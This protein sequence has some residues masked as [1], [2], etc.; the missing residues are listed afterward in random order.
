M[1]TLGLQLMDIYELFR[2]IIYKMDFHFIINKITQLYTE[3]CIMQI[4]FLLQTFP[5]KEYF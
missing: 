5:Q 1:K 3:T 4:I 2:N